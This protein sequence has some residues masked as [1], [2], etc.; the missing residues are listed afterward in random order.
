MN[1]NNLIALHDCTIVIQELI[2][3]LSILN[4]GGAADTCINVFLD[5]MQEKNTEIYDTV[6]QFISW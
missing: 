5:K 1:N 4:K 6:Q 3:G 2:E